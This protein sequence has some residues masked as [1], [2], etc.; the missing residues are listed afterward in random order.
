MMFTSHNVVLPDGTQTAPGL[1][2]V[3]ESNA[4][5]AALHILRDFLD[6]GDQTTVAD[7]GSLEG[8]YAYEFARAG[9]DVTGI[10]ARQEHHENAV[11][12]QE[13]SGLPNLRFERGDARYVL[14]GRVFDAVFCSGLLY[15]IGNPVMFLRA[16]GRATKHLLILNTHYSLEGGHSET[17][18]GADSW[19]E[20][21][22]FEHEGRKGHWFHESQSPWDSYGN[23]KSFWLTKP[24]LLDVLKGEAGFA[25]VAEVDWQSSAMKAHV[26][27]GA[28]MYADR[29]MFVAVK[30]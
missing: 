8:G 26:P 23:P 28:G 12:L 10:E 18:H 14:Q 22:D 20:Y 24:E 30:P 17:V 7:L 3:R 25:Q 4:C 1:P 5:S 9:Y 13:R 11:R 19:C 16:V 29:G 21:G 2:L 15:H 27:G 6:P